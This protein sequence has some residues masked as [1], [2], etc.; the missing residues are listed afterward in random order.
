MNGACRGPSISLPCTSRILPSKRSWTYWRSRGSS[1]AWPAWAAWPPT[2]TSTARQTP[3]TRA[4]RRA[5]QRCASTPA[6][7]LRGFDQY[8][9]RSP[10]H[11]HLEPLQ[12]SDL[13]SLRKRQIPSRH[14]FRHE[15]WHASTM[16]EPARAYGRRYANGIGR[17]LAGDSGCNLYP[18]LTLNFSPKRRSTRRAHRVSALSIASSI[19]RVAP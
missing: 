18:E 5:W 11:Q 9:E 12:K 15:Q 7:P 19:L 2:L 17:L 6:R 3:C 13:F 14:R 8:G 16:P 10:A 4:G 1:R